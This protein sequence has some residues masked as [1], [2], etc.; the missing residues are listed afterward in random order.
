MDVFISVQPSVGGRF[1]Y[2]VFTPTG[3]RAVMERCDFDGCAPGGWMQPCSRPLNDKHMH[4]TG[5]GS[6]SVDKWLKHSAK[7]CHGWHDA[8]VAAFAASVRRSYGSYCPFT[9]AEALKRSASPRWAPERIANE[10]GITVDEYQN[11]LVKATAA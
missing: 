3:Y 2:V 7:H 9:V 6:G 10:L 4:S 5:T 11:E 8:R 1:D